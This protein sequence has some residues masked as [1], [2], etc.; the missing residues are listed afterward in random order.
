LREVQKE[1]GESAIERVANIPAMRLRAGLERASQ[2]MG[3]SVDVDASSAAGSTPVL[4]ISG[5]NLTR[6]V[7]PNVRIAGEQVPV[8]NATQREIFV[9]P[10][11]H[12][13]SGT[14]EVETLPGSLVSTDLQINGNAYPKPT[15][16]KKAA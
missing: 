11:A 9:R 15:S 3:K 6:G 1:G 10:G 13:L 12:Q 5:Y 8:I 2:P 4:R 16:E 14:L 7:T